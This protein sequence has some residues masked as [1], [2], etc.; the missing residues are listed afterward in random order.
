MWIKDKQLVCKPVTIPV[1][2]GGRADCGVV[3]FCAVCLQG[4]IVMVTWC[5][6][7]VT[8]GVR[9]IDTAAGCSV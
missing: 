3:K 7:I 8:L 9:L 6:V 2:A 1:V 4:G 5:S